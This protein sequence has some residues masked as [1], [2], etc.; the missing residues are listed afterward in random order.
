MPQMAPVV[1]ASPLPNKKIPR[2]TH[3]I[4]MAIRIAKVIFLPLSLM[5]ND[6]SS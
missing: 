4:L 6:P 1:L 3:M 2:G 5:V